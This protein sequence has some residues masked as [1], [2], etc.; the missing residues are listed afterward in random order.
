MNNILRHAE[1]SEVEISLK[2]E[3]DHVELT[4]KDNGKGFDATAKKTGIGLTN[5]QNRAQ[6]YDGDVKIITSP[7][8]GCIMKIVFRK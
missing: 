4:M 6:M 8:N 5:I 2:N 1:A 3:D 7:G